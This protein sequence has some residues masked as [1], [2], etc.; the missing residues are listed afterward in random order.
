MSRVGKKPILIPAG[1]DVTI[2]GSAV[3]VKGPKGE[4][5][6]KFTPRVQIA[7]ADEEGAR[8]VRVTVENETE[9]SMRA[10]WGTVRAII[11]H[12]IEG[13]TQG[14]VRQLEINGIGYRVGMKGKDLS[15]M[16]GFSHDVPFVMPVGVEAS[17]DG[18]IITIKGA[19]KQKVGEVAANIRK[20]KKPEPYKGKGIKYVGEVIRRKAGKA[21]KA[22]EK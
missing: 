14:F 18:N 13:V 5:T 16:I 2:E 9:K 10:Q 7:L 4:L 12:M 17:V 22:A 21:Q 1:V 20:M 8:V 6:Q 11:A 19:D 15:L 3:R